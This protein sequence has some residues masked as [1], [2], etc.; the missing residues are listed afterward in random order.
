MNARTNRLLASAVVAG[1][2]L[3]GSVPDALC[4]TTGKISG[5]VLD[6]NEVPVVGARVSVHGTPDETT[7]D[8]EGRYDLLKIP[9]GTYDLSV[10]HLEYQ[11][12]LVQEVIVSADLTTDL[13]VT[14]PTAAADMEEV[15][16]TATRPAV[17]LTRTSTIATLR[18]EEIQELPVQE[19]QDIVNLQAGVVDGHF[20][21]GRQGEVQF[22]VDGISVNNSFDNE[23]SVSLDR[24]VLQEVQVISGTFDAEYGQAMSGV[25]N[26]VLR[27]GSDRYEWSAETYGGAYVFP[28]HDERIAGDEIRPGATQSYQGTVSG[29]VGLPQTV[30]LL[31]GR[32]FTSDDYLY[33]TRIFRITDGPDSVGVFEPTGD[34]SETALGYTREWFGVA[35]LTNTS[36]PDAKLSY[37]AIF[38]QREGRRPDIAYL[39]NPE[40]LKIQETISVS[41]GL[42]GTYD[43]DGRTFLDVGFR[44][45]HFKYT[46]YAFEDL[47]DPRYDAAGPPIFEDQVGFSVGGVQFD[48]FRQRTNDLI[49]KSSMLSQVSSE[50]QVKV[51]AEVQLPRV[52]FGAPGTLTFVQ[53]DAGETLIRHYDDPPDFPG[54][55]EYR[56]VFLSAYAQDQ[57]EWP[58]LRVR[59]G[60]RAE[61]FDARAFVPSD[62]SNPANAIGGAPPSTLEKASVKTTLAPRLGVAYPIEDRAALHFSYGHFFQFPP[63]GQIFSNADYAVLNDLQSGGIDFG[64]LGN[65]DV[66]PEKTVQY[67]FGY[68]QSITPDFGLDVTTFYKDVRDL[69]GVEFVTTYNL[70]EY[71]RLT[72]VDFGDVFGVTFAL[73]HQ[74]LGPARVSLDYTWQRA[75]GNSSDPR[76]TATRAEAGENPRPRQV[77]FNW[78]QTHTLNVTCSFSQP[79]A[80]SASVVM[81]AASGQPYTPIL[82]T[83]F[84]NALGRNSERKPSGILFDARAERQVGWGTGV[85]VF[86]RAFNLFDTRFFNGMV[87]DSS[88]SPDYSRFPER[89]EIALAD[90]LRFYPPRRIEVGLRFGSEG[91]L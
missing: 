83:G 23:S 5:R 44:H 25:V 36:L 59:A 85:K 78:D 11:V 70:A 19:L 7:S 21:G 61:Y 51:G 75:R 29:P 76:E 41:H 8:A 10:S 62:L 65:P 48:R 3:F 18:Y 37:Q 27:S 53:T 60:L 80:Y 4:G 38:N 47:L 50:H 87:F 28:G 86:A 88:G 72:N 52:E 32:R 56:P 22:Q 66:K 74:R 6:A 90:P 16:V 55:R 2:L 57:I 9:A 77:P 13:D 43:F 81:R 68:K 12:V 35:K 82:E 1:A 17:D 49:V 84:G 67:E 91:A 30:F 46:D 45:N 33:A 40:G 64:V 42:D 89:D 58:D 69:L 73:D 24:S 79:G 15:V 20:R 34:R 63:V 31:S 26:A 14:L 71:A 39:F 54:P